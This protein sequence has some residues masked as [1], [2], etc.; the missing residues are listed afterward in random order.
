MHRYGIFLH[1]VVKISHIHGIEIRIDIL[2]IFC[3]V[4]TMLT[5]PQVSIS[6]HTSGNI[7]VEFTGGRIGTLGAIGPKRIKANWEGL[8]QVKIPNG[9]TPVYI[10]YFHRISTIT[11][12]GLH[13]VSRNKP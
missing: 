9:F 6:T 11:Q 3:I 13:A 2:Q 1:T 10:A 5:G 8:S 12:T 4:L 7:Q